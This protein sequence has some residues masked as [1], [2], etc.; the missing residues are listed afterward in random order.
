MF[1]DVD[2]VLEEY[3]RKRAA[4][5]GRDEDEDRAVS[6]LDLEQVGTGLAHM[7]AIVYKATATIVYCRRRSTIW[8]HC[9]CNSM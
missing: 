6:D 5:P 4:R 8:L 3:E 2:E 7:L 1:G 9:G